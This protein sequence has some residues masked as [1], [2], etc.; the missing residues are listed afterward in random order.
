MA[1]ESWYTELE[2]RPTYDSWSSYFA[3]FFCCYVRK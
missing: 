2:P 1:S 3:S